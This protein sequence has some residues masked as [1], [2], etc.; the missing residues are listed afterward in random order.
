MPS[1][2]PSRPPL[3]CL[4]EA[5]MGRLPRVAPRAAKVP[6]YRRALCALVLAGCNASIQF[7]DATHAVEPEATRTRGCSADRDCR[8]A[9]LH[10]DTVAHTCVVCVSDSDCGRDLPRCDFALHRCIR[11]A[12][13]SD[14]PS[15]QTCEAPGHC[16]GTCRDGGTCPPDALTCDA[17]GLCVQ[18]ARDS[19]C[20][21]NAAPFCR[22]ANGECVA[23]LFD[24]QCPS[25]TPRCDP[26]R[27]ACVGCL[28]AA[29]CAIETEVCDP[30]MG[31][32]RHE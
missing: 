14:C 32:C 31:V 22:V 9:S 26:Y 7:D 13:S 30:V 20:T 17:R 8:L 1:E 21:S 12:T 28:S 3:P 2:P 25:A 5:E 27:N 15:G 4:R 24:G 16:V 29:D 11:C 23:C 18:C 6:R 10:C 19:D